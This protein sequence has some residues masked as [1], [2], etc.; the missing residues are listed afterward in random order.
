MPQTATLDPLAQQAPM[1]PRDPPPRAARLIGWFLVALFTT[2][3]TAA[4]VVRIPETVSCRFLL[5]PK[6][7]ADPIQAPYQVVV[8]AVRIVEGQEVKAGDELFL[9]HSDEI[10]ARHTLL[11]TLTAEL[12]AKEQGVAKLEAL[13]NSQ[14]AIKNAE[15]AQTEREIVFRQ[16]HVETAKALSASS[17]KLVR[18][19]AMSQVESLRRKLETAEAETDLALAQKSLE[20]ARLEPERQENDRAHKRLEEKAEQANLRTRIEALKRDLANTQQD[21]LSIRAPYDAIVT[22]LTQKNSGNVLQPGQE[23]CQL[24]RVGAE[25]RVRLLL[26]ESGMSRLATD[27]RVRLFFDAYPYQRYGTLTGRVDWISPAAVT[28]PGGTGFVATAP[29]D[30]QTIRVRGTP[31]AVRVGMTGEA[32]ITVGSNALIEYAF[33]PIRQLRENLKH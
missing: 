22:S 21:Q 6:D 18:D 17:D 24:A 10:R 9:L 20:M 29:L 19:G 23:L 28:E 27:Q 5:V 31:Q 16:K 30:E 26:A 15:I 32:R 4:I 11:Q 14:L 12:A 8:K 33:E 2:V 13:H 25:P 1:L 7:G 3:V